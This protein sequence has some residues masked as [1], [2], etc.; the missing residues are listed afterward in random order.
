ML[1]RRHTL[2]YDTITNPQVVTRFKLIRSY[3]VTHSIS[4]QSFSPFEGSLIIITSRKKDASFVIG[5]ITLLQHENPYL[6]GL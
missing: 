4:K 6:Y 1:G 2:I 3:A 5:T